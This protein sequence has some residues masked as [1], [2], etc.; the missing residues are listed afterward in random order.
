MMQF[1]FMQFLF[2]AI[3]NTEMIF[4]SA[5]KWKVHINQK[6]RKCHIADKDIIPFEMH[7]NTLEE[8]IFK[9]GHNFI[10]SIM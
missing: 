4:L 8:L 3:H 2:I 1:S 6:R 5:T 7:T 9:S 10:T